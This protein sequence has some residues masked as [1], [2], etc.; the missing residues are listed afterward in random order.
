LKEAR[1]NVGEPKSQIRE[2]RPPVRLG[3]YLALVM[4]IRNTEPQNFAQAVDHQVWRDAMVE[5]YDS[6]VRNDVWDVVPRPVGKLVVT[7]RLLY[8]IKIAADGS[9]EKHKAC[10][11][12]RGFSHIEG[13]DYD[14]TFTQVVRYTSIKI[15]ISITVDMGWRIHKMDVK[16][17]FLNGFIE[18]EVYMKQPQGFEVSDNETHV[19]IL[20]KALY[21]L[22]QAPRSWYS[23]ID[24]YFLQ[25]GFKKSDVDPNLYFIIRGEYTLILIL[26]MDDLFI[27]RAEDLIAECKLGLASEFEMSDIR[28]MHYF[29][30]M[31]VWQ[32]EGHIFLGR[33]KY[34]ADILRRF[35]MEDYRPMSTPMITNWKNLSASYS[36]LVDAIVY[37]QLIGSLMYLVNTRPYI[38]FTMNILNQ[39][40]V[41]PRSV[42]MVGAKHILRYVARIVDYVLDHVRGDGVSLVGYIDLDWVGCATDRKST[43]GCCFSLGLGLVSWF[44]RK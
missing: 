7:S 29:L 28:L 14:E 3:A 15:I 17:T 10:F 31:E 18:E 21:G 41:E 13:V 40:I 34:A 12:A 5:E 25:M 2:S 24:T 11:V 9:V 37:R 6:I 35:Q 36:Q 27:T 30:G 4:S 32:E 8:K 38:C 16:T 42:H 20:R 33:G 43:S 39:Y 1:E 22:K 23:W 26:Y 44:S 19:F